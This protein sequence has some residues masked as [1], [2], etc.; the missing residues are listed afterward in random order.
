MPTILSLNIASVLVT[1]ESVFECGIIQHR[2]NP[3]ISF[4]VMDVQ[5]FSVFQASR[6]SG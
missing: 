4:R 2:S 3:R 5:A 1:W 6:G